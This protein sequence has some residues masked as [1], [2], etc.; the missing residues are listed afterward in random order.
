MCGRFTLT[1]IEKIT[2]FL[3]KLG[4]KLPAGLQPRYNI[5]PSQAILTILNERTPTTTFTQWGLIPPWAKDPKMGQKLINARY[6]TIHEKPSFKTPLKRKR[7]LIPA[8]GFYEWK[9]IRGLRQKCPIYIHLNDQEPFA[10][11]G[12]WE[13][14]H[15]GSGSEL[16]TS[17]IITTSSNDLMRPFHHRMPVILQKE[18][19]ARWIDQDFDKVEELRKLLTPYPSAAMSCHPV[20]ALVNSPRNEK[21]L[22]IEPERELF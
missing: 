4:V 2:R 7:C 12:L 14:W 20:S 10:F 17:T 6:E 5:A 9:K 15:D 13:E 16:T 22:C 18:A 19:L 21:A 3:G 1:N 11:A 8:D